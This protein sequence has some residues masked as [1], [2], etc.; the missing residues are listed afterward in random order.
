MITATAKQ[1]TEK[2]V[3]A[4][5]GALGLALLAGLA[6]CAGGEASVTTPSALNGQPAVS[7]SKPSYARGEAIVVSFSDGPGNATDWIGIYPTGAVPGQ[8]GSTLWYYVNGRRS[9]TVAGITSGT[10]T[11]GVGSG[12][13]PLHAGSWN[14]FF[15]ANDGYQILASTSLTVVAGPTAVVSTD[16]TIYR[17]GETISVGFA[18]GPGNTTDWIGIY[19]DGATP[20]SVGST[21]WACVGGSRTPGAALTAGSVVFDRQAK[22]FPLPAGRWKAYFLANDGL[23]AA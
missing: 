8:V 13:W 23:P 6:G 2:G 9:A 1:T 18:D 15:L 17:P 19:P 11:L 3:T 14:A 20:G 12:S 4:A 16:R 10:L 21:M 22:G 5:R 7:T